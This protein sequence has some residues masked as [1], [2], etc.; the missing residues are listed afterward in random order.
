LSGFEPSSTTVLESPIPLTDWWQ[1]LVL[2]VAAGAFI[3]LNRELKHK[4]AGVRTHGLV[5]LGSATLVLVGYFA[6]AHDPATNS[7]AVSPIIQGIITGIGFLGAG[8]IIRPSSGNQVTGLTTAASIWFAAALGAAA[9]AGQWRITLC[10]LGLALVL[11]VIG[12]PFERAMDRLLRSHTPD[13][14]KS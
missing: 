5:A 2:A 7:S 14:P 6:V 1:R 13:S 11:L 10:A 3:G 8:V 12:G 9:G 4:P